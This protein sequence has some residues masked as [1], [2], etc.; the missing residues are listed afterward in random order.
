MKTVDVVLPLASVIL[1][2]LTRMIELGARRDTTAGP[3]RE[4]LTL[5]LFVLAGTLMI[6]GSIVEFFVR[7][8]TLNWWTFAGGWMCAVVSVVIRRKAIAAL[9]KFW[10]L[11]VEI[12][13]GHQFVLAG[14]FRWMRHPTYFSMVL[15]LLAIGL[16]TNAVYTAVVVAL[17]FVPTLA[18]RISLEETA[19]VAK[20]GEMYKQYQRTT[21]ALLPYK[22]P[23]EK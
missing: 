8:L 1:I 3:I 14:P 12:R 4:R 19:L 9:G 15:E 21:P 18:S 2:Y 22:W 10:S 11:H 13:D 23:K 5:R 7:H 17:L 20:F 6:A 16:V